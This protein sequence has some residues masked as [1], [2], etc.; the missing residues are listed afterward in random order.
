MKKFFLD[1]YKKHKNKILFFSF[2]RIVAFIQVL[3]WPF[4]FSKVVN[5]MSDNPENWRIAFYWLGAMVI[6]KVLEDLIR[7][8]AKF[9]LEKIGTELEISL[10]TFFTERTELRK[11][12][13]TGESVQAIKR[14]SENI[15]S[16]I[17]FYKD[18]LLKL[19]VNL[20]IIPIIFLRV[21][22][23]YLG[24]LIIYGVLYLIIDYS[25]LKLYRQKVQDSF[26]AAEI[27]WGTT[28]RKT[29]EVWR[30][31]EDGYTFAKTVD[32]EGKD[33]Y[34]K[35]VVANRINMIR[36]AVLQAFS[37]ATIGGVILFVLDKVIK[38]ITPI[39][40]LILISGYFREMQG[41]L[42]IITSTFTRITDTR[43]SLKR[44]SKAVKIK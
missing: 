1:F 16:L 41:T 15:N 6:N 17:E 9:E 22:L 25:L 3:F 27:F 11:D 5:I 20:I 18:N 7:I 30:Q 14:A 40:N 4:A 44:L 31:R 8:K 33:L 2:L 13:K 23:S 39:G 35:E 21:N 34:K 36:W 12:K 10:A 38:N 24:L 28:Y 26:R 19:P 32:Q 42:N 37:S 43:I 29:P